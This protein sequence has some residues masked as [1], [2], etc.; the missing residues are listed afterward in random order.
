MYLNTISLNH[1]LNGV[2]SAAEYYFGKEVSELDLA[3]CAS[4]A[5]ITKNPSKY[6]PISNPE[7]NKERQTLVLGKMLELGYIT[8][9]EYDAALAEDIYSNLVGK[10]KT[11]MIRYRSITILSIT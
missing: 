10:Q 11:M 2:G 7:A 1:G 5:G 3:E 4:I 8:Q 9:A 6:S